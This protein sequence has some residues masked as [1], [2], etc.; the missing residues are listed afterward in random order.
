MLTWNTNI[1]IL[2]AIGAFAP[3][4]VRLWTLRLDALPFAWSTRYMAASI[5]MCILGGIV[6]LTLAPDMPW[7][8][9]HAGITTP[10]LISAAGRRLPKPRPVKLKSAR[11]AQSA[12]VAAPEDKPGPSGPLLRPSLQL[13]FKAL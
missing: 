12:N 4:V 8:S 6:A 1:F 7:K 9:L 2:G 13:F 3:E 11:V 5:L 10:I